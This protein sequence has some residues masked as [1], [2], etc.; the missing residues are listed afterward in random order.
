MLR[1][2][3]LP[4]IDADLGPEFLWVGWPAQTVRWWESWRRSPQAATFTETDWDYLADTALLHAAMWRGDTKAAAEVRLR[5]AAFG[6][7]PADRARLRM[8]VKSP[9]AKPA[10]QDRQ[11]PEDRAAKA[12]ASTRSKR[13]ARIL[14]LV[15]DGEETG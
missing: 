5:V 11:R 8:S 14:N 15:P 6:A 3:E 2:P 7:T 1:G 13:K 10:E 4:E 9:T 12:A